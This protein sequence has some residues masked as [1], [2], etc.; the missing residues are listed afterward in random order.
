V[1]Q[2]NP[3]FFKP[4]VDGTVNTLKLTCSMDATP[5][6][7]FIKGTQAQPPFEIAGVIGLTSTGF[8]GTI[9]LCFPDAVFLELMS[10]MLGEKF[11]VITDELQDGAA[12]LLNMI[13]GQAKIVL[14][15][16][17]H[18]IQKAIPTVIRGKSLHTTVLGKSTVM[19]LP[20]KT[21]SGEFHIEIC[22]EGSA[23]S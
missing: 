19:V 8:T 14:N 5:L 16:Q 11:A 6:K 3:Q 7:P 21:Q 2:L 9:T 18:T 10:N 15:Q 17:G 22:A 4:F 23:L 12:E 20:F 1:S 13:F